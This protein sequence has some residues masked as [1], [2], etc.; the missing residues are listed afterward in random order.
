[1]TQYVDYDH[2]TAEFATINVQSQQKI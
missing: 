2:R 1:M